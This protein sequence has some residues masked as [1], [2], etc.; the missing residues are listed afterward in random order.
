MKITKDYSP[1]LLAAVLLTVTP[2]ASIGAVL[3]DNGP[4]STGATSA[5][6]TAAPAGTT[7]SEVAADSPTV[8]NTNAGST[9]TA[10]VFR[11][12][13]NF[14]IPIGATWNI[15]TIDLFAYQT[16]STAATSP[17]SAG[18]FQVW[19]GRPGDVGSS[20]IFGNTTTNRLLSSTF[21]DMYRLF[22]STTPPPGTT[23]GTTRPIFKNTVDVTGLNLTAGEYWIDFDFTATDAGTL[24]APTVTIAGV[25]TQAGWNA[26]QFTVGTSTYADI[27]DAGNPGSAPDVNQDLPFIL[28]GTTSSV[29]E[30]SSVMLMAVGLSLFSLRRRS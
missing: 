21:A 4:L 3:F 12:M 25:R 6:G 16:G 19:N 23:V 1:A 26:R 7:W 5:S 10:G 24:F 11:L 28:N 14:S 29:P 22:N 9:V 17:F 8:S 30:P 2:V 27:L 13:D 20:V 18:T 15:Q